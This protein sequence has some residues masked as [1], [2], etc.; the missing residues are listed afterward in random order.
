[1]LTS[2]S[3][4][5]TQA[6]LWLEQLP[7]AIALFDRNMRYILASSR[8]RELLNLGNIALEGQSYSD[9][10][11][12]LPW[13]WST[14]VKQCLSGSPQSWQTQ[15]TITQQH[16]LKSLKWQATP[17]YNEAGEV[18]GITVSVEAVIEDK[19][20]CKPEELETFKQFQ[21]LAENVPGMIYQFRLDPD[22]TR[23]FPY[24]SS[25]C[26]YTYELEPEQVKQQP[27]L[28]FEV[29]HPDD[30]VRLENTIKSSAETLTKWETEW[31]IITPNGQLKWLKGISKP[32][33]Q[34]DGAILW[35]GCV[36]DI[37]EHKAT[38]A[39]LQQSQQ[40]LKLV[41]DNI[42][43]LIFWK[44][45]NLVY[46]GCNQNF[47]DVAGLNSPEEIVGKTD[48]DLPWTD[49]ETNWY[50]QCDRQVM[51]AGQ[52]ELHIIETQQQ[53]DGKQ[54]WLD[55]NKIPLRDSQNQVI[56]ILGT[57]ED[58]TTRKQAEETLKRYNEELE[59]KVAERTTQL[60]QSL[61]NLKN[62]KFAVNQAAIVA[63]TDT[64]GMI[65]DV[66][67]KFCKISGYSREELIGQNHRIVNSA[68]HSKTFFRKMW[69]TISSG[70]IWQGEIKNKAKDG[71]Y[72]W[73]ETTIV[74]LLNQN[75]K[76]YQYISIR[77]DISDRKQAEIAL[78][79]SQGQL[80]AF[81]NHAP[82]VIFL[83]SLKGE[84]MITNRVC[85]QVLQVSSEEIIGKTDRDLFPPE[86]AAHIRHND[87]QVVKA[88]QPIH[89]EE[90]IPLPDGEHIYETIKF[91][92]KDTDGNVYAMGGVSI[93]I[94]SRKRTE[95][96]L[97]QSEAHFQRLTA[98]VPGMLYQYRLDGD[99]IISYP[100]VSSGC[101]DVFGI[102]PEQLQQNSSLLKIHS[103]DEAEVM[104]A[105]ILS[106]QTLQDWKYEWRTVLPS[107]E[108]KWVQGFSRP[109]RQADGSTLW[110]G[111]VID[112]SDRKRT[113]KQLHQ[114]QQRLSLMVEQTPLA[115]IEWNTEMEVTAWNPAAERIFG[116]SA[117]E[118]MG[119][120]MDFFLPES[121]RQQVQGITA[122][123]LLQ[124]GGLYNINE[125][126]RKD[127]KTIICEWYNTPLIT[128]E[129]EVI[130]IASHALDITERQQA[131]IK[132]QQTTT[133]LQ[134]A[135]QLAHIGNWNYDIATGEIQWSEEVFR[136]YGLDSQTTAPSLEE[137][138]ALSHPEDRQQ[139]YKTFT[140]TASLGTSYDL[141]ARIIRPNGEIRHVNA[142]GEAVS[143]EQGRVI[144]MFG[145]IMDIT[146]RKLAEAER[147]K[148][149]SIIEASS[150][151]IGFATPQG[152]PIYINP[153]GLK[154]VGLNSIEEAKTKQ[155]SDF[156]PSPEAQQFQKNILPKF[157]RQG[158]WQGELQFQHFQTGCLIPID[159]RLFTIKDPE[160]GETMGI[161]TITRN[162]TERKKAEAAFEKTTRDLQ[163][164]QR[165]A[166]IGNWEFDVV[167]NRISWS[168]EL[169]HLF[170]RPVE[171][172]P[173]TAEESPLLYHPEERPRLI[174][175]LENIITTAQPME[176][177]LRVA[178][179][180]ENL[181]Y[182]NVKAEAVYNEEGKVTG[183][184]GTIMDITERKQAE[185]KLQEQAETLQKTLKELQ[186]TQ[187]Q[188][189]QS[190][191][192][193]S[194]GQMVAGVAHEINNPV[195]FIHGNITHADDYVQDLFELLD[196]YQAHY[197]EPPADIQ[198]LL[199]EVELDFLK[200][201]FSKLLKSMKTGTERIREIVLSLRNFSRL[202]ESEFKQANIHDGINSTLLILKNR[203]FD[204]E[205]ITEYADLPPVE[206]YPGQLNQVFMNILD[207]AI[208][209]LENNPDH[210]QI[211]IHTTMVRSNW[212][213][214]RIFNSGPEISN[215]ICDKVFDPFFTTKP[216]GQGTG[217]GLSI[218]YQIVTDRHHG[219]IN[220]HPI[221]N[222]GTEFLIE[223]PIRQILP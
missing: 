58:I 183:L 206:C 197:P 178:T 68:Y 78:Q 216:I 43:Q 144:R 99:G 136:I 101:R 17:W 2:Q 129:G 100:Y 180:I 7:N 12:P 84:Y 9:S 39:E 79:K 127:S 47:A 44:D 139:V 73:V 177:E 83:K 4:L 88:D 65:T 119:Q 191:K 118:A 72:Y 221:A 30:K 170:Q 214:I 32:Q 103:E 20:A 174:E 112:I 198:E 179:Q 204:I 33:Y 199:K 122:S 184:F 16:Q 15:Q 1:M 92:V 26:Y 40:V 85:N 63:I 202:D 171:L 138:I 81:I 109:E 145:T 218:S 193:S 31:R 192:M 116:F 60:Q 128:P 203:L 98:N 169:F 18:G 34:P 186:R 223:I 187:A 130:G 61:K 123:L 38:E 52:P 96:A 6:R 28:L 80:E 86:A 161:A 11:S 211:K 21:A 208:D 94:T 209:V 74:P 90:V 153:A 110:S 42:P 194:L 14:I 19:I 159:E 165:I 201:D 71:S 62:L 210:K 175:A 104:A 10:F 5:T 107:G 219:T 143:D 162:I 25:G 222:V 220:C 189:I 13:N 190:E 53:A 95:E 76:P 50:R 70:K 166:R 213:Q 56:G 185:I 156:F 102:E 181:R 69:R 41:L 215:S 147:Q 51:A 125:N 48:D 137:I 157:L 91:P 176:L 77:H 23:S 46:Q 105:I 126:L 36:I 200:E 158:T 173:P 134:E 182:V 87:Q 108:V 133:Q 111:C 45:C 24:I 49:E 57:I 8:W 141:E 22:G 152:Q 212:I 124:Q 29:V 37:S 188:M 67:D 121:A 196:L 205:V 195:S 150:D 132:L 113:E 160:T 155:L 117:T 64:K 172:G 97:Q 142:K 167:T 3:Q 106:A 27:D 120:Y 66:N 168:E 75:N 164:A 93:D 207:N 140:F 54:A 135:Q 148:L 82:A 154:M 59:T 89:T 115:V 163:Q 217:L 114:F 151:F 35:D 146:E 131:E 149:I 55:T